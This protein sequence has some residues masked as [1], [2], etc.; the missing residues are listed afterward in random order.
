MKEPVYEAND[1]NG[2]YKSAVNF[3]HVFLYC[4]NPTDKGK[5]HLELKDKQNILKLEESP[6]KTIPAD[7][8]HFGANE[9]PAYGVLGPPNGIATN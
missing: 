7:A 2:I 9:C 4:V 8:A 5:V 1:G 3:W 6:Y